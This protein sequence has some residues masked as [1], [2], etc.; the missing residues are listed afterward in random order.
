MHWSPNM[1]WL[2][3]IGRRLEPFAIHNLTLYLVI[4][5]AFVYL[6]AML[7]LIDSSLLPLVPALVTQ[8]EPWRLFSFV[9]MPPNANWLFIAFALYLFFLFGNSLEEHWGALRYNL[10]LLTG[11]LLTVGLSFLTPTA[12][13]TNLFIGSAVFLAFAYLYPDFTMYIFFILPVKIK[14]LGL[15]TWLVFGYNFFVSGWPT[16]F[17]I[18]GGVG[19]FLIFFARDIVVGM[20]HGGRRMQAQAAKFGRQNDEREPRHVCHVCGKTDLSHPELDFRYCSKCAGDQC[21]C[22]EHL[23]AH[24]HVLNNPDA[25]S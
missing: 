24:E 7:G 2:N 19:N 14:W 16:R 12:P 23:R 4:G 18:L 15:L 13:A 9:F 6:S 21:Y 8:G 25:K 17:A 10:F 20:R 1:S 11:Y 22:P 3:K 5:Q